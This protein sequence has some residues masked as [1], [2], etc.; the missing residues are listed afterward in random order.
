MLCTILQS[1]YE[2]W[3]LSGNQARTNL[4]TRVRQNYSINQLGCW[5]GVTVTNISIIDK[6]GKKIGALFSVHWINMLMDRHIVLFF[7]SNSILSHNIYA[8]TIKLH[9]VWQQ[10]LA[11]SLK[12]SHF[13]FISISLCLS[14]SHCSPNLFIQWWT[15][16]FFFLY[17]FHQMPKTACQLHQKRQN[18]IALHT[19]S[20][21]KSQYK[22]VWYFSEKGE[23]EKCTCT[24]MADRE[25]NVN[26]KKRFCQPST[27]LISWRY[28]M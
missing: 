9:V 18:Y 10:N 12:F 13:L 21:H 6:T 4:I 5:C 16:N 17:S 15:Y 25:K 28:F 1:I 24:Q 11:Y 27:L 23:R 20:Q 22:C 3:P 14:F 19:A 8:V 2:L 7:L 26:M